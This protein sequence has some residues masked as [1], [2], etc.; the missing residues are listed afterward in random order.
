LF[1]PFS[2]LDVS[3]TRKFG[4][5]GLGLAI[6]RQLVGLL[7]GAIG[8]VSPAPDAPAEGGPGA[9][10][11]F[12]LPAAASARTAVTS[13]LHAAVSPT[14]VGPTLGTSPACR[15]LVAEDNF[16]NQQVIVAMLRKLGLESTLVEDGDAAVQAT[17]GGAFDLVLMDC[18]MPVMDGF[19]ATREIRS[20]PT[21]GARPWI[22]AV[23]ANA[24]S[25]D[26]ER[27]R[28]AGMDDYISKPI[29][30]DDLRRVAAP[31]LTGV[32]N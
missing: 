8:I 28:A 19:E 2:Q 5:T 11:W 29:S 25:G 17:A 12:S 4:G 20:R 14:A 24:M 10:F 9:A 18:Q 23:T 1:Q 26:A 6:S 27:C 22:V 31:W 15:V 16:V 3:T 30:I 7:G 13:G 21:R 32:T